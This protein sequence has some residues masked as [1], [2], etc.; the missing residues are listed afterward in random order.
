MRRCRLLVLLMITACGGVSTDTR[1]ADLQVALRA[2]QIDCGRGG[3]MARLEIIGEPECPLNVNPDR[4]VTGVCPAVATGRLLQ[5]RLLYFANLEPPV[6]GSSRLDL[7]STLETLDL[8][9]QR[10]RDVVLTF[11]GVDTYP[12]DDG[13][14]L[15]NLVEWCAFGEPRG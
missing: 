8:T 9:G 4:T 1:S 15:S 11:D 3:L 14:G 6:T 10:E 7:A 5:V 2:H 13:D 12:D